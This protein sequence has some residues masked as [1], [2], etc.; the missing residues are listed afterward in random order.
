MWA[1]WCTHNDVIFDEKKIHL[2]YAGSLQW[3]FW[4]QLQHKD[5]KKTVRTT[6]KMLEIIVMDIFAKNG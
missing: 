4:S 1:I 3:R 5:T 2:L 6:S